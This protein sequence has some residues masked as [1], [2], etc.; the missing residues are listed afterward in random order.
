MIRNLQ[1]DPLTDANVQMNTDDNESNG[2]PMAEPE[3]HGPEMP[4]YNGNTDTDGA[5]VIYDK[6]EFGTKFTIS[7]T[8]DGYFAKRNN[9]EFDDSIVNFDKDPQEHVIRLSPE[10][11]IKVLVN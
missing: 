11:K 8:K 7:V 9:Y 4:D 1:D 6:Y 10:G 3:G 5:V 2:E